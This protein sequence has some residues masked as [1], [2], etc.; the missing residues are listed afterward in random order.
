ME[1]NRSL[2]SPFGLVPRRDTSV[3][4]ELE[5]MCTLEAVLGSKDVGIR[6]KIVI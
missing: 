4:I 6:M 3:S 2:C 5:A 1:V